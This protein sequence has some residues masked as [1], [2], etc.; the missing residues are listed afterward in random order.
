M[1]PKA[2]LSSIWIF[3]VELLDYRHVPLCP[4]YRLEI[5]F[6][7]SQMEEARKYQF[8][9]KGGGW[10][11]LEMELIKTHGGST[12]S[13]YHETAWHLPACWNNFL[14]L[15]LQIHFHTA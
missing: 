10:I 7:A 11:S 15:Q 3:P 8:N 12:L 5:T 4:V 1:E 2:A 14:L 6:I 9:I 13:C